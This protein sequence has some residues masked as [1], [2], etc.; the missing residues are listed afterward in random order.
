MGVG[1]KDFHGVSADRMRGG[2]GAVRALAET[3][4]V[5]GFRGARSKGKSSGGERQVKLCYPSLRR[6]RFSGSP[7]PDP[8]MPTTVPVSSPPSHFGPPLSSSPPLSQPRLLLPNASTTT[9]SF[10]SSP[11]NRLTPCADSSSSGFCSSFSHHRHGHFGMRVSEITSTLGVAK[12]AWEGSGPNISHLGS[13]QRPE[14]K[15]KRRGNRAFQFH[16]TG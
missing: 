16:D 5:H 6:P 12:T 2:G 4:K 7:V 9:S 1:D 11:E 3:K 15:S 8:Y 13:R 10:S 14:Q